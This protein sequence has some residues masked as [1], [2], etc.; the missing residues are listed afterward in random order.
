MWDTQV[1]MMEVKMQAA[2]QLPLTPDQRDA[3]LQYLR[4]NAGAE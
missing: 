3:I 4:R 2:G 1:T